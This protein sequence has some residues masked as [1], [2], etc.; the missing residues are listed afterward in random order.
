VF[1]NTVLFSLA[2]GT[3]G[4]NPRG[5]SFADA[6]G[7]FYGNKNNGGTKNRGLLFDFVP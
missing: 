1:T 4:A 3:A 7:G 2:G 5:T 6:N